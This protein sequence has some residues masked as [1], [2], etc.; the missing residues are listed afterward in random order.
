VAELRVASEFAR[1]MESISC[2]PRLTH[3]KPESRVLKLSLRVRAAKGS[4]TF[5]AK[6]LGREPMVA[7]VSE[8]DLC[9]GKLPPSLPLDLFILS[10]NDDTCDETSG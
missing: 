6:R 10:L 5:D 1:S 2:C 4:L 3:S 9:V 8:G 7:R